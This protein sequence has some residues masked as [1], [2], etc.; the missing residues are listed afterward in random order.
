MPVPMSYTENALAYLIVVKLSD[1]ATSLGWD[2]ASFEVREAVNDALLAYGV[3][4][5]AEATDVQK[6]RAFALVMGWRA[7]VQALS[8]RYDFST[9]NHRFSR[10]QQFKAAESA[11]ATAE[12]EASPYGLPGSEVK[13]YQVVYT[14]DPYGPPTMAYP[15]GLRRDVSW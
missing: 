5:I 4:D 9:G 6:L 10:S 11:L 3:S 15:S 8:A 7:A 13:T 1:V 12:R 14:D 2:A